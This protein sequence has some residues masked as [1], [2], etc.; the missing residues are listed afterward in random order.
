MT[1]TRAQVIERNVF[2]AIGVLLG[3]TGRN[4][5]FLTALA[6]ALAFVVVGFLYPVRKR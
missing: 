4:Q 3:W 5:S 6:V 2:M 1:T